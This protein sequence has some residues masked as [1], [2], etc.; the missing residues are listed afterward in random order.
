MFF[1]ESQGYLYRQFLQ[2]IESKFCADWILQLTPTKRLT[3][4]YAI[5]N[6]IEKAGSSTELLENQSV[7]DYDRDELKSRLSGDIYGKN[8][9]KYIL[10]KLEY[11]KLAENQE[12]ANFNKISIEHVLPQ[13]PS[14]NSQWLIDFN[15]EDREKLTHKLGNLVLLSRIKNSQLNNKDFQ[16]KKERYFKSSNQTFPN[17]NS[18]LL[19]SKWGKEEISRRQE[20]LVNHL[21]LHFK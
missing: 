2:K 20:D 13:N 1:D 9:S 17:I 11:I 8:F 16:I 15:E 14:D 18:V 10:L 6:A 4:T 7:F 21:M 5:I 12:F 3:N 19:K